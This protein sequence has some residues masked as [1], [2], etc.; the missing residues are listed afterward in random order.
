M[1]IG[2]LSNALNRRKNIFA[3]DKKEGQIY[4]CNGDMIVQSDLDKWKSQ[5]KRLILISAPFKFQNVRPF[6][7][8]IF[9]SSLYLSC[10]RNRKFKLVIFAP[11]R[12]V[13]S[14]YFQKRSKF[15]SILASPLPCIVVIKEISVYISS[16]CHGGLD[17]KY[18]TCQPSLDHKCRV[19]DSQHIYWFLISLG[20]FCN[21]YAIKMCYQG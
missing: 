11:S 17:L 10:C 8:I 12:W 15:D 7:A 18:R 1:W 5:L 2:D 3:N 21:F 6:H 14:H 9:V 19:K 16:G 13:W 20:V 4:V